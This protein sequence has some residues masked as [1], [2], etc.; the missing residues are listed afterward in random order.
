M[1]LFI[2][3]VK[4]YPCHGHLKLQINTFGG[5]VPLADRAWDGKGGSDT[6]K[7]A[8]LHMALGSATFPSHPERQTHLALVFVLS[9]H[10]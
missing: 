8:G 4:K 5:W 9:K 3:Q 2:T 6:G 1:K 7:Q 10:S